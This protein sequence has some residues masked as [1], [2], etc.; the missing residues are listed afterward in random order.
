MADTD[1]DLVGLI[2]DGA[3]FSTSTGVEYEYSNLGYALLGRLVRRAS[4]RSCQAYIDATL[5]RPLGMTSTYW[6][7]SRVP[8]DVLAR[9]YRWEDGRW[10]EETPLADGSYASMGGLLSSVE[11]FARYVGLH[12]AAWPPRDD[13]ETGPLRRASLREMQQP[14]RFVGLDSQAMAADG[15]PCPRATGYGY[16]LAWATDCRRRVRVGHSGGLPGFGSDWRILPEHGVGVVA[17]GNRTYSGMWRPT[18]EVLELLVA[19]AGLEPRVLPASDM[20]RLRASQLRSLLPEWE[21]AEDSGWFAENFFPDTGLE[22]R[23]E[24]TR[25]LFRRAGPVEAVTEVEALNQLR[26]SFRLRGRDATLSV[27]L[28]LTPENPPR[29]QAVR[30]TEEPASGARP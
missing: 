11:D 14:A 16:G 4:G 25:E 27:F 6:E 18:L 24:Q 1:G 12:L 13:P 30:V 7:S 22:A 21:G 19:K 23:R 5:L 15:T 8:A 28:T 2:R 10:S 17:F 20:L 29:I 9:G 3:W 26:G